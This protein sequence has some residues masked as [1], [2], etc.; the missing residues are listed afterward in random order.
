MCV[1]YQA[2][3]NKTKQSKNK[4]QEGWSE[5]GNQELHPYMPG[6]DSSSSNATFL[7]LVAADASIDGGSIRR[8]QQRD[9]FPDGVRDAGAVRLPA[10]PGVA[11][12]T[13]HP[14]GG[15]EVYLPR[16]CEFLL[17]R[18]WLVR[19]DAR[20][21]GAAAAGRLTALRGVS[22]KLLFLWSRY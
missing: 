20:V 1:Q 5:A 9:V 21:S 14:D 8:Q 15:F 12:Y 2:T 7:F 11:G 19:S 16:A 13:L 22:V 10:G 17:S 18:T 6:S 3:T 4:L